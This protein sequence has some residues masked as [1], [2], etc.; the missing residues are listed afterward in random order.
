M[1]QNLSSGCTAFCAEAYF[2]V[3]KATNSEKVDGN[4]KRQIITKSRL[5]NFDP[6]KPHLYTVKLE[7]TGVYDIFL[8]FAKKHRLWYSL[9][10]P[11]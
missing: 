6:L 11:H 2:V 1:P 3:V 4:E 7:F 10:P 5:Y 8:I 9:E